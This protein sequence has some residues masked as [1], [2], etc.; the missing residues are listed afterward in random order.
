MSRI[1]KQ[2]VILP[3][4]VKAK[5]ESGSILIEGPKGKLD[6]VIPSGIKVETN[7]DKILAVR[8][9]DEKEVRSLHGTIRALINNMI[10][11]V[12]EGYRKELDV[13]GTGYKAQVKGNALLLSLGFSHQ[14]E[15]NIPTGIKISTPNPNRIIID[16]TDKQK[17]GEFA[18]EI[19]KIYLP[20]P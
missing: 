18:S 12:T 6:L 19:R 4:G 7:D 2:P 10:K 13:V 15:I 16:G 9:S 11:G 20:E 1:G 14:V 3:K 8:D 5:L 17:V